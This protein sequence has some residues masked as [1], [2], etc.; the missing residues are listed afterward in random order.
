MGFN[1]SSKLAFLGSQLVGTRGE[2]FSKF[3]SEKKSPRPSFSFAR[4]SFVS[5]Y[6]P[7]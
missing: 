3:E 5:P 2:N 6:L 7:K 4:S 1:D